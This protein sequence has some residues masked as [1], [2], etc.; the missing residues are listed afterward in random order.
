MIPN[1][2]WG[3]RNVLFWS[4][5]DSHTTE[6]VYF[7][8]ILI[9]IEQK[10]SIHIKR[11]YA[12]YRNVLFWSND[13][14]EFTETFHLWL[15]IIWWQRSQKCSILIKEWWTHIRNSL[16]WSNL[17]KDRTEMLHSYQ[18]MICNLQKY[19]TLI[20]QWFWGYKTFHLLQLMIEVTEMF[21]LHQNMIYT[22]Q[23]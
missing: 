3:H 18:K 11:W 9:K 20:K 16:L 6:T 1:H 13:D 22:Q 2:H 4:K 14:I 12:G 23:K 21:S 19:F 5:N 7:N 15:Y 10:C 17:D 8:Q